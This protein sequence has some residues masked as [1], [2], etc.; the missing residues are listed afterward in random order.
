MKLF[1]YLALCISLCYSTIIVSKNTPVGL[2]C[3]SSVNKKVEWRYTDVARTH[4]AI[5]STAG[6]LA[7]SQK[8]KYRY[9]AFGNTYI[10]QIRKVNEDTIGYYRCV[11]N[12]G[13]GIY[14]NNIE[15]RLV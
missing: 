1:L 2:I 9:Y 14:H 7:T 11:E 4:T 10:L 12:D 5:L 3:I 6:K 13:S 8:P 15:V